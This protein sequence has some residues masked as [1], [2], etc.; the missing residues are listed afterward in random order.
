MKTSTA[1]EA[2]AGIAME[3]GLLPSDVR[4]LDMYTKKLMLGW[5][6]PQP[7]ISA[8]RLREDPHLANQARKKMSD[9]IDRLRM[10]KGFDG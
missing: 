8:Q 7:K 1:A 4:R 6:E 10:G 2:V 9:V 5:T 3:A